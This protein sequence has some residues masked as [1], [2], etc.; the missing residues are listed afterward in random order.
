MASDTVRHIVEALTPYLPD[1]QPGQR[2]GLVGT[3]TYGLEMLERH[4]D[5]EALPALK[6]Q[7]DAVVLALQNGDSEAAYKLA[8]EWG[9]TAY[10]P[11]RAPG[12][13]PPV[14]FVGHTI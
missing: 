6:L 11:L 13:V 2:D 1:D 7:I 9:V 3:L 10:L 4:G 14:G 5:V 12:E 8:E